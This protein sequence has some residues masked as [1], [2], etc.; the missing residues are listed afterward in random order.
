MKRLNIGLL[1]THN[2]QD[3]LPEM[4]LESVRYVDAIFALDG[5]SDDTPVICGRT[6]SASRVL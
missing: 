6:K 4:L 1:M 2:E 3:V 5:S